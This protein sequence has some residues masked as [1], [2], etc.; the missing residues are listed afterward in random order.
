MQRIHIFYA[1]KR[2]ILGRW[3]RATN[4]SETVPFDTVGAGE[5]RPSFSWDGE[6]MVYGS[7]GVWISER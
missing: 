2:F 5:T 6:R 3:R 4:L 7:G 1:K